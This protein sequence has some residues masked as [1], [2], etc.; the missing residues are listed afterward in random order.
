MMQTAIAEVFRAAARPW[1]LAGLLCG[2]VQAADGLFTVSAGL[3]YSSGKYGGSS[4]T[5]MWYAPL[6][7]KYE[8]EASTFKLNVPYLRITAPSDGEVID[9]GPDG[10]PIYSGTGRRVTREGLGDVVATYTHAVIREPWRNWLADLSAK[11]KLPTADEDQGLGTGETD[12]ALLADLYYLAGRTSPFFT[13]EYRMPGD[14][15]GVS[16]RNVWGLT[17]GL[18][19]QFSPRDSAGLMA[20]VRQSL[21]PDS[22]E[23]RELTAYWTHKFAGGLKLQSYATT[24]FSDASPDHEVGFTLGVN[25]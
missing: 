20:Y 3:D 14:P 10:R 21:R 11:V 4:S 6:I 25:F 24:G 17:V 18:G 15:P 1:L 16:L 13:L 23:P 22:P 5:D 8:R 9:I 19:Y 2:P 12:Y 7:L